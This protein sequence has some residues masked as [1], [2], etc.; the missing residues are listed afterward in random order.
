MA[1][2]LT[3][4][5]FGAGAVIPV[6]HTCDGVRLSP[7]LAW[8]DQPPGTK[9]LALIVDDPDAPGGD[10]FV[11]WVVY[12]I[13]PAAGGLPMAAGTGDGLPEGAVQGANQTGKAGYYPPC[14]PQGRHRYVFRLL[15]LDVALPQRDKMTKQELLAATSGHT[16]GIAEL[17][18]TY[19]RQGDVARQ[20]PA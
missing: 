15:A 11:H 1:F 16:L 3:S 4:P 12:N 10:A 18:G 5:S 13:D 8:S 14:P 2:T 9:S 7:P 6:S 19:A 17:V 20:A